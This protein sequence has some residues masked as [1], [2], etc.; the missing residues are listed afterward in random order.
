M[1]VAASYPET[2]K[3]DTIINI[4]INEV[5]TKTEIGTSFKKTECYNLI[6]TFPEKLL[7]I[8]TAA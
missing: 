4:I 3:T 1:L 8:P 5:N 6:K 7:E 2:S